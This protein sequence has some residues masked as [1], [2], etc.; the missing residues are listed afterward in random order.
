MASISELLLAQGNVAADRELRRGQ[1][2]ASL[3]S[4]AGRGLSE[5]PGQITEAQVQQK[6]KAEVDL[7]HKLAAQFRREDGTTDYQQVVAGLRHAGANDMADGMEA[8][9][10][11]QLAADS[12]RQTADLQRQNI[13]SEIDYRQAQI[14][15]QTAADEAD[16]KE[17]ADA[18]RRLA[19]VKDTLQ[20]F[21]D[22]STGR[23]NDWQSAIDAVRAT[24]D[25]ESADALLKQWKATQ[26]AESEALAQSLQAGAR[27]LA[28]ATTPEDYQRRLGALPE[29]VRS[30][31][32]A[33]KPKNPNEILK[34]GLSLKDQFDANQPVGGRDGEPLVAVIG[35]DGRPVYVRRSQA[36]GMT[37][38]S[39]REQGRPVVS[40][41][42]GDL[43][44]FDTSLDDVAVLG[45]VVAP[46]DPR[47]GK[48]MPGAT[49][50]SA[51]IGAAMPAWATDMFGWGV[52]AKKKQAVIDRVKQVIGKT[53]EGGVL[54][55]EDE[56]KY[57][58]ILPT[59]KDT[60]E[61]V[62]TK[63]SG[64]KAA[65]EKRKQR[66]MDALEDAGYDVSR[67]RSRQSPRAATVETGA[68][69]L[70]WDPVTKTFKK[71]GV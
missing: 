19:A 6:A 66:R 38:A 9:L 56:Y 26:G 67:F 29:A 33:T 16:A 8:K 10:S 64:L 34:V 58:K 45:Q 43:A 1:N 31:F 25:I 71:G 4:G 54:R 50:V 51:Q 65:I 47:T 48:V 53:L 14:T 35:K 3:L 57:E 7:A 70:V 55:K 22:P 27:S 46:V 13:Q 21:A 2:L 40:G 37:P 42:A 36:E 44:D 63:L 15:R 11:Q 18:E 20:K 68:A 59:I 17:K 62:S 61:V 60:S 5:L 28:L 69:D 24:G 52:D 49:G 41:D 39:N 30:L 23:I 32:P 12:Q